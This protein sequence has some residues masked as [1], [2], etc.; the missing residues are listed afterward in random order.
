MNTLVA[1]A[2]HESAGGFASL[3]PARL[4]M[5]ALLVADDLDSDR[6]LLLVVE[7]PHDLPKGTLAQHAGDLVTVADVIALD[8][9]VVASIVVEAVVVL[10]HAR[11]RR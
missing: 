10:R 11:A 8:D 1:R 4:L 3:R 9:A 6:H 5:E 2:S 7:R